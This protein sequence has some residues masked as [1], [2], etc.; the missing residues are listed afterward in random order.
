MTSRYQYIS[1]LTPNGIGQWKMH[2]LVT[3]KWTSSNPTNKRILPDD[4]ILVDQQV[5][6]I[7]CSF[8]YFVTF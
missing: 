3:R 7:Y 8:F 4:M 6:V 2:V 1:D 5:N